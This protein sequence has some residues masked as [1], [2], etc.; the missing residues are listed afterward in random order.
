MRYIPSLQV[1][2]GAER[3]LDTRSQQPHVQGTLQ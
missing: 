3:H 1:E 2:G